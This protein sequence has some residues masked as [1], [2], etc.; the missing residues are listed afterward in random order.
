MFH[1]IL[2]KFLSSVCFWEPLCSDHFLRD[3]AWPFFGSS[4]TFVFFVNFNDYY[5]SRIL[6]CH[7]GKKEINYEWRDLGASI[8]SN[9]TADWNGQHFFSHENKMICLLFSLEIGYSRIVGISMYS[10]VLV[11]CWIPWSMY[12][13]TGVSSSPDQMKWVRNESGC[14]VI[15]ISLFSR[16]G[17]FAKHY[18][19]NPSW[20]STIFENISRFGQPTIHRD[21]FSLGLF[22]F[23]VYGW[24]HDLSGAR[25]PF[26]NQPIL[27]HHSC[28]Q[29]LCMDLREWEI[30]LEPRS[31]G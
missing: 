1:S 12:T 8:A 21:C 13:I 15:A 31:N 23:L 20:V 30:E 28:F 7:V 19:G 24:Q 29:A 25:G 2:L 22:G 10:H 17:M 16:V 14:W 6:S 18:D 5:L 27:F 3:C 4:E 26:P 11:E 9:L